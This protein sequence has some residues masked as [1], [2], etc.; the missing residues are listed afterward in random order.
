VQR[1]A[2]HGRYCPV[3]DKGVEQRERLAVI[4]VD[5]IVGSKQ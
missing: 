2:S 3:V 5:A 4:V 1:N